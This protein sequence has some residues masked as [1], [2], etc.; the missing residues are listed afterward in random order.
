VI[1]KLGRYEL[2]AKV[3]AG[4]M[5]EVYRAVLRGPD[6]F[7]KEYAIKKMLPQLSDDPVLVQMFLDEARLAS[8]LTHPNICQIFELGFDEGRHYIAMEFL[9]G[10]VL[11]E[12]WKQAQQT[13]TPIDPMISAHVVARAAEGLSWAHERHGPDDQPLGIVHRDVSPDNLMLTRDGQVKVLD[14]G[15]ARASQRT[16]KTATGMVRGKVAYMAPEQIRGEAVDARADVFSL[17]VVLF[18]LLSNKGVFARQNDAQTM[19]AILNGEVP[20]NTRDPRVPDALWAVARAALAVKPADR[21]SSARALMTELDALVSKAGHDGRARVAA[22]VRATAVDAAAQKTSV[23]PPPAAGDS[24]RETFATPGSIPSPSAAAQRPTDPDTGMMARPRTAAMPVEVARTAAMPVEVD[25]G[26]FR[27]EPRGRRPWRA[28]VGVVVALAA[29]ASAGLWWS[30]EA[31]P[32]A[33][34]TPPVELPGP[35][36]KTTE[37]APP[38]PKVPEVAAVETPDPVK[39]EPAK[40]EVTKKP[41]LTRPP[42]TRARPINGSTTPA[43]PLAEPPRVATTTVTGSGKLTLDT[44][45]WTQVYLGTRLLGETPLEA[46][47][48]PAGHLALRAVNPE[49]KLERIIEVDVAPDQVVRLRKVW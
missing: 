6:G 27:D 47:T 17:G 35:A 26:D 49:L 23:A 41:E 25:V 16:T 37:P 3:A 9:E 32:V 5:A 46:V 33:T 24:W 1:E 31:A 22:L 10:R 48:V 12:L 38:E 44:Q 39:P 36:P 4:G 28:M 8:Q 42:R 15:I 34:V 21:V 18:G 40:P 45:P 43:H 2:V 7:T 29:V 13:G 11:A 30:R 14:F 20:P 19:F